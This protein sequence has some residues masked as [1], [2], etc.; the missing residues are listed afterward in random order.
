MWMAGKFSDGYGAFAVTREKPSKAHRVSYEWENGP[1][2][3]G[4]VP[5][6]QCH[7]P[8]ACYLG[9]ECPHRACVNPGHVKLVTSAENTRRQTRHPPKPR[10]HCGNNHLLS[11][12][13]TRWYR[14]KLICKLCV[15]MN[16]ERRTARNRALRQAS[17]QAG[18]EAA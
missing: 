13:N 12:E 7:D 17:F 3:D 18:G 2:P 6:H 15:R 16:G 11:D 9:D 14:G 4:L 10:T 8:K 1:I 5:D